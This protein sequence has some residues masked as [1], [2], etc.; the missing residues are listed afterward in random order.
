VVFSPDSK[1]QERVADDKCLCDTE[2]D[3]A[4]ILLSRI[5]HMDNPVDELA[6]HSTLAAL[7]DYIT[8]IRDPQP[9]ASRTLF[10]IVR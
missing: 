3:A 10:R 1:Q 4:L 2:L 8:L 9:R 6:A 5:S 7:I